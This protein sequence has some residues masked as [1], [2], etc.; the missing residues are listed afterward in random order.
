MLLNAAEAINL[1]PSDISHALEFARSESS[2]L[3]RPLHPLVYAT[4]CVSPLRGPDVARGRVL[5][6]SRAARH[7]R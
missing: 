5:C 4:T 1:S 3:V 7:G 2:M 6:V